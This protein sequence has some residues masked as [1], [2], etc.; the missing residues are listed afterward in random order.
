MS[1]SLIPAICAGLGASV[2]VPL[3]YTFGYD[4]KHAQAPRHDD[5]SPYGKL[6]V[7]IPARPSSQRPLLG[8]KD[9]RHQAVY[10]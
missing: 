9:A 5:K 10:L 3:Q 2:D 1:G 4:Q 7:P 8:A 6:R